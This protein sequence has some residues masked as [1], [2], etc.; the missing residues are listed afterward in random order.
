MGR[1]PAKMHESMVPTVAQAFLPAASRFVSRFFALRKKH[2]DTNVET[3]GRNACAT[4]SS[5]LSAFHEHPTVSGARDCSNGG[6]P[7]ARF[8]GALFAGARSSLRLLPLQM[9]F[10]R[11]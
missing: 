9:T 4:N 10:E 2:L 8:F 11:V 7:R 3:A 6:L 5:R 1:W